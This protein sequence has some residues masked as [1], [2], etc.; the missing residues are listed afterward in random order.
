MTAPTDGERLRTEARR[1]GTPPEVR[2]ALARAALLLDAEDERARRARSEDDT[3][4]M[5]VPSESKR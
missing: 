4:R 2:R 5:A 1:P 3:A